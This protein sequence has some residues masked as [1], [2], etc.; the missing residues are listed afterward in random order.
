MADFTV[1]HIRVRGHSHSGAV[2]PEF[3]AQ[4]ILLKPIQCRGVG[5]ADNIALLA[6]SDA[7]AV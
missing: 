2:R 6:G 5:P 7:H 1:A 4:G 3:R